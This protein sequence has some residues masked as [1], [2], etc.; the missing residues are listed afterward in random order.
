MDK[1]GIDASIGL[2]FSLEL[3]KRYKSN[4]ILQ[5]KLPRFPGI[6]G[7]STVYVSIAE[8]HMVL[9]Y[10]EDKKQQHYP[11]SEDVLIRFDHE[12]GPF[13][14]SFRPSPVAPAGLTPLPVTTLQPYSQNNT[15]P[16]AYQIPTA[17]VSRTVS[18]LPSERLLSWT[19]QQRR[20]FLL[21]W[22]EIDGKKTV[23]ELKA[24]LRVSLSEAVVE[25]TL[26]TLLTLRLIVILT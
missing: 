6:H 3:F 12:K 16:L 17:V 10:I 14:W 11:V 7:P 4:G 24:A 21:V 19:I 23:Q 25:E 5:A 22:H 1:K 15:G 13:E 2:E 18:S 20:M 8:G 9:C 26:H